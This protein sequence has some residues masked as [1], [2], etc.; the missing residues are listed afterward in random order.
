M[1]SGLQ[2]E[3]ELRKKRWRNRREKSRKRERERERERERD[4]FI[5]SQV[6]SLQ[7]V[8]LPCFIQRVDLALLL[9][10]S[11][12]PTGTNGHQL[13]WSHLPLSSSSP[14]P[15][16]LSL[17]FIS[18]LQHHLFVPEYFP[19]ALSPSNSAT[20]LLVAT[21][22]M[23]TNASTDLAMSSLIVP[24]QWAAFTAPVFLVTMAMASLVMT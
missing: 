23:R 1:S 2:K 16:S 3:C 6:A 7:L 19:C 17:S 21:F 15:L 22:Q 9:V 8:P 12:S 10:I 24:I 13:T 14:L 11:I 5:N 20:L 4:I 18:P